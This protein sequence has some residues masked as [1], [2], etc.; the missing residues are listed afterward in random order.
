M[1]DNWIRRR[2]NLGTIKQNSKHILK[3]ESNGTLSI[4]SISP[5]CAECTTINGY[6]GKTLTVTYRTGS[7][8]VQL[9]NNPGY[10]D[11]RKVV[12]ITYEDGDKETLD[13]TARIT[14]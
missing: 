9:K 1:T 8:P 5:G 4:H 12:T 6:D 13:F 10:Q 14:K 11:V 3:Y 7:L 2:I